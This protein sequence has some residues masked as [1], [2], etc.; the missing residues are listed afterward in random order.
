MTDALVFQNTI[1]KKI[2]SLE[3]LESPRSTFTKKHQFKQL[4]TLFYDLNLF[5]FLKLAN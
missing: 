4:F 5:S 1:L 2:F 3:L